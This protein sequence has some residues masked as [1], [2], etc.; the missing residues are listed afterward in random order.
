MPILFILCNIR[1]FKIN[2]SRKFVQFVIRQPS[3]NLCYVAPLKPSKLSNKY[4]YVFFDTECTQ[5]LEKC[6]RPFEHVP[7]LICAQQMCSKREAMDHVDVDCEQCGK[8]VH[9]FWQDLVGKFIEYLPLSKS[10]ADN[11]YVISHTSRGYDAQ[12]LLKRFLELRW[13]PKL[14]MG[15]SKILG[16]CAKF[17]FSGFAELFAYEFKEHAQII[18]PDMQEGLLHPHL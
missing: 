8:L 5:D 7:N 2:A 1:F 18:Q 12:F 9:T 10:F 17:S 6:D 11:I 16:V 4:L 3:G 15:S 14:I 13:E